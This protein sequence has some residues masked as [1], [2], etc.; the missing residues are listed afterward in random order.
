MVDT[1]R[2]QMPLIASEQAL[3]HVTHN[4]AIQTLD[5]LVQIALEQIDVT[6]PPGSPV[7]GESYGLGVSATG[8]WAGQDGD[9]ASFTDGGW[10]FAAP[11]EGWL[12]WDKSTQSALVYVSGSWTAWAETIASLQNLNLLGVNAT[13]DATNK[14]AVRTNAALFNALEV[15]SGGTGDVRLTLNRETGADTASLLFQSGFSGRA[16]F[17]IAGSDDFSFKVSPDGSSFYTGMTID[18]DDGYVTLNKLFGS[19]P[20]F[21]VVA[22]GV[23]AVETSYVIP[24]PETGTVDVVDTISG[25]ADGAILIVTGSAGNTLSFSD[26]AGNL[27]LGAARVLDNFEDSLMLVRRDTDWIE[28]SYAENG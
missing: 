17:G 27:K 28:L 2:L 12:A 14:L 3:K 13:A 16:E 6:V 26:G 11:G 24:A 22:S 23:L 5:N 10:R 18:K 19:E 15:G 20:S 4:E 8:D 7:V 25:G 21:P 1:T 9:I